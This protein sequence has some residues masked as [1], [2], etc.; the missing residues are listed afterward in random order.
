M[1]EVANVVGH[2]RA[3]DT[4]V[5]GPT[6]NTRVDEGA[7]D[8]Q[9]ASAMEQIEQAHLA[10]GPLEDVFLIHLCPRHPPAHRGQ[11]ITRT[12]QLLLLDEHLLKRSLPLLR[13]H[14]RRCLHEFSFRFCC[15]G[16]CQARR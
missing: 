12:S 15:N 16:F 13:R 1:G 10:L 14:N 3:A 7:I 11:R 2:Q 4:A 9:L 8:D 5:F 6:M